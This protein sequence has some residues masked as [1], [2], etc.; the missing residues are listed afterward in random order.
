[1][2][3]NLSGVIGINPF[4]RN[5]SVY[6]K[7]IQFNDWYLTGGPN[8]EP[9]GNIQ[10]VGR[11]TGPILA[12]E[13]G[14]PLPL[15]HWIA[16]HS[17]H[18]MTMSED[19]PRPESRVLVKHGQVELHWRRTNWAAHALLLK[20]LK[21]ALRRAGWPMV[22]S[23]AFEKRTPSHQCGTARMGMEPATSVVD[24]FGKAHDLD[25]LWIAD[26]SVLPTSA[27]VNPSLTIAALSMRTGRRILEMELTA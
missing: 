19:L 25:N 26:A 2:N 20:R 22:L 23:K 21:S 5:T 11:I 9:L 16:E 18:M 17:V 24:S 13:G 14:L 10:M 3:H 15:A 8:G 7:T 6:E 27:A 1:M 4:R 12:A